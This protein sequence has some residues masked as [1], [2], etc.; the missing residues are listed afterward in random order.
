MKQNLGDHGAANVRRNCAKDCAVEIWIASGEGCSELL[1]YVELLTG[2]EREY[3]QRLA[4][5][6]ARE[7]FISSR[8]LLR[9]ALSYSLNTGVAPG[10]WRFRRTRSGKLEASPS[11]PQV[12]FSISRCHCVSA[13]AVSATHPVG[14]DIEPFSQPV[15]QEIIDL[16]LSKRER[17]A[18]SGARAECQ[19][20]DFLR[21]WTLKEAYSKLSGVGLSADFSAIEFALGP[22]RLIKDGNGLQQPDR[23]H[24]EVFS[25][26]LDV[27][28]AHGALA[29]RKEWPGA[30]SGRWR[31]FL[32]TASASLP[33][34]H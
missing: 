5:R 22:A 27:G 2:P 29:I 12:H 8:L 25:I 11:L 24:F 31:T 9:L 6:T 1:A 3:G 15:S 16:A 19:G 7:Q 10:E 23:V 32:F 26:N 4:Q 17:A 28:P 30:L 18:I 13:V 14:F 34:S 20:H 21:L 33:T